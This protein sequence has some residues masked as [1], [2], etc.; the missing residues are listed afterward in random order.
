MNRQSNIIIQNADGEVKP[1]PPIQLFR[2]IEHGYWL[3][4]WRGHHYAISDYSLEHSAEEVAA[5]IEQETGTKVEV[6]ENE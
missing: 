4:S 2:S 1:D 6:K 5:Y 3:V